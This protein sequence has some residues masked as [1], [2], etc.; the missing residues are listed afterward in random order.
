MK[1]IEIVLKRTLADMVDNPYTLI[2]LVNTTS[3]L[4]HMSGNRY[5]VGDHISEIEAGILS[6]QPGYTVTIVI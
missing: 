1:T 3:V 4:S 6:K 2:K 5:Y